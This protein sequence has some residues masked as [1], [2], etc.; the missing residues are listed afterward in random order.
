MAFDYFFHTESTGEEIDGKIGE[1]FVWQLG[2]P[3]GPRRSPDE[4]R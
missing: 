2:L 1:L 3:L 4:K